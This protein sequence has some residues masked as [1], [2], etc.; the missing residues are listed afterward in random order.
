MDFH[1]GFN[2]WLGSL[3]ACGSITLQRSL[4][5]VKKEHREIEK[6]MQEEIIL[7]VINDKFKK[8][9]VDGVKFDTEKLFHYLVHNFGLSEKAKHASVEFTIAVDAPPLDNHC[10]HVTIWFKIVAKDAIDSIT[11]EIIFFVIVIVCNL[12]IGVFQL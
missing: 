11:V 3:A 6:I 7:T 12:V 2:L 1:H 10:V 5:S 9:H 8:K 4:S